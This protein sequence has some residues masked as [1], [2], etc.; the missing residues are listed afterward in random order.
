MTG[1][2]DTE[3]KS[4]SKYTVGW[5]CALPK[6]QTAATAMLDQKHPDLSQPPNDH[7]IYTLGSI[8]KHNIVIVC[9]PKGRYGTNSA[10]T[11]A[12]QMV[13][14]FPSIRIGLM[15]GIGGGIPPKVRLGDVVVSTPV[16]GF[17]GVVQW[18]MGKAKNGSFE[19]TGWLNNPPTSLLTALTKLETE[20]DLNGTKIP[21]FLDELKRKWPR[22]A[23]K[24]LKYDSFEDPWHAHDIRVHYGLIA[25]GNQ[26]IKDATLRDKLDREFGS[27]VL[28]VEMEAAG[29][30]NNFPCIVIRGICDYA[31]SHKNKEWQE[32][33]ATVAAAFTK[34]LLEYVQPSEVVEERPVKEFLSQ[35]FDTV[36]RNEVDI[37]A[38]KSK[39]DKKEDRDIL[40]WL[41]PI[42]YGP[43]QS[44]IFR[45]R[46]PG[47]GQWL[48][49]SVEFQQWL[50]TSHQTLFCPGIPGAGKTILTSVVAN[51]LT[52]LYSQDS[53]VGVA[54]IY[55]NFQRKDEQNIDHL[56]TSLLKQLAESCLSLPESVKN[57][58]NHNKAQKTRP[59]LEDILSALHSVAAKYLRV[60]II[61]D[62][63]D[64]C[65]TSEDC[66]KNGAN[67]FATSR[68]DDDIGE[69]FSKAMRL[70]I[71]ARDNDLDMYLDERMRLQNSDIF[72]DTIKSTIK[73]DVIKGT[74][75]M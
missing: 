63:L 28:C 12:T 18:D 39:L 66:R 19:R 29:L 70:E 36:S 16:G 27:H 38:V 22:L 74:D 24:Y 11:V 41:T 51:T 3:A 26:V 54:Y 50:N 62:A 45:R 52:N 44:D 69:T 14:T 8:G 30:M 47:T 53:S 35:I 33:A 15:V 21:E 43:Q 49:H 60:F 25:S 67:I 57:L 72:D 59:S 42:D 46:Q 10:A 4:H 2:A 5:I 75:G 61:V 9:L 6:E 34:E 58:F 31:D 55:C 1:K 40:N 7:N 23:P 32:H 20:H 13:R 64:E 68:R 56:L 73:R 71:Y 48:L 17:P 65:Q 37:K